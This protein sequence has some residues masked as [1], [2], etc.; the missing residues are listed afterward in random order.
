MANLY[1]SG[2]NW[3]HPNSLNKYTKIIR[4]QSKG[5][6][7]AVKLMPEGEKFEWD[8]QGP[9]GNGASVKWYGCAPVMRVNFIVPKVQTTL[10]YGH[11][12]YMLGNDVGIF[13]NVTGWEKYMDV[14][15]NKE[16]TWSELDQVPIWPH[17]QSL[18]ATPLP[19]PDPPVVEAKLKLLGAGYHPLHMFW[20]EFAGNYFLNFPLFQPQNGGW[21]IAYGGGIANPNSPAA[22]AAALTAN[23]FD[24]PQGDIDVNGPCDKC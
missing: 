20:A 7:L 16:K 13:D 6:I 2:R 11:S 19:P 4:P 17:L 12:L 14:Y 9:A 5:L 8:S 24:V 22:G 10:I 18:A 21:T 23:G 1:G 15:I 3:N